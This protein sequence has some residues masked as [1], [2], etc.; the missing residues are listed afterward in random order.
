MV[1][2]IVFSNA[3]WAIDTNERCESVIILEDLRSKGLKLLSKSTPFG[4]ENARLVLERI[5]QLHGLSIAIRDQEPD[6]FK[7]C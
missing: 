5:G 4:F 2:L 6:L 1:L 7:K 3:T